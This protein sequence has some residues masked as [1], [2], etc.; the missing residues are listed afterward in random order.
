[1]TWGRN[2]IS[3]LIRCQVSVVNIHWFLFHFITKER[4]CELWVIFVITEKERKDTE[5]ELL[6]LMHLLVI[7][8]V[9]ALPYNYLN[10]Y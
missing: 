4:F 1:M 7:F 9:C 5:F 6:Y 10:G 2:I 8:I 3:I